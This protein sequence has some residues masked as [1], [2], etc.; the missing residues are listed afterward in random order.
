MSSWLWWFLLL[1]FGAFLLVGPSEPVEVARALV[2]VKP[3]TATVEI[4]GNPGVILD[5]SA[6]SDGLDG[7]AP[8]EAQLQDAEDAVTAAADDREP[9]LDGYRQYVGIVEDG[10]RKIVINSM[11]QAFEDWES[12]YIEVM[13][14][15]PCF[16]NAVYNV[17][18]GELETLIVNG[19]A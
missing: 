4:N 6:Y 8:G 11:C 14:G 10:E 17:E 16:W 9:V 7:W 19:E 18:T 3:V 1:L 15:G 5:V 2:Q 12:E 13:D